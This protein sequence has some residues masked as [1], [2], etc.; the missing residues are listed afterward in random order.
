MAISGGGDH[1]K[2]KACK[3]REK[4]GNGPN[5]APG[6]P[7]CFKDM[8]EQMGGSDLRMIIQK[9]LTETDLSRSHNRLSMP[10]TLWISA[11][12]QSSEFLMM[13][14]NNGNNINVSLPIIDANLKVWESV[15]LRMWKM[16]KTLLVIA[17][18]WNNVAAA[19]ALKVKDVVQIW[20]FKFIETGRYGLAMVKIESDNNI[21]NVNTDDISLSLLCCP[22]LMTVAILLMSQEFSH[23][24]P[25]Q[26][27]IVLVLPQISLHPPPISIS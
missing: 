24:C 4:I 20:C 5:P 2:K 22:I 8:I 12:L 26:L 10:S 13:L 21:N 25:T 11:E 16:T 23:T 18:E 14:E 17:G 1:K 7:T 19:N 27:I 9:G 15:S 3:P 6:I